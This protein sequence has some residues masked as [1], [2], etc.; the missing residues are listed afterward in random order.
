MEPILGY[1][2][3]PPQTL[4]LLQILQAEVKKQSKKLESTELYFT[5]RNIREWTGYS[6]DQVRHHMHRL[7][8][9]EQVQI[10]HRGKGK[11]TTYRLNNPTLAGG[12]E[13]GSSGVLGK[14]I[15][16]LSKSGGR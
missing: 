4:K 11:P 5:R 7:V 16:I 8:E 10:V 2:D 3:I 6:V 1:D 9:L 13:G 14:E 12:G 15:V